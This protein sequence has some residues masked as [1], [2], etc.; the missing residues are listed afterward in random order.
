M[1]IH[2]T[3]NLSISANSQPTN[4]TLPKSAGLD[5]SEQTRMSKLTNQHDKFESN[6]V[7]FKGKGKKSLIKKIVE[8]TKEVVKKAANEGKNGDP[9]GGLFDKIL[10]VTNE[11]EV[12]IQAAIGAVLCIVA[13]PLTLLA[14]PGDKNK[15][16]CIYASAH[17]IS[18]GIWG[19]FVPFL[20]VT[21]LAKG[22]RYAK[23]HAG[24]FMTPE[25]I[26]ERWPH[27]DL[28][29]I[30]DEHGKIKAMSDWLDIKGRKF[31]P[32]LK[33][34][35]KIPL[36]KNIAEVSD[37]TMRTII[38]Q[39][40]ITSRKGAKSANELLDKSGKK[41]TID[42]V[43]LRE[44]FVAVEEEGTKGVKYYPLEYVNEEL[45][46]EI[47][48]DVNPKSIKGADGKRLHP[49]DWKGLQGEKYN[50]D[51]DSL[52]F[53][54]WNDTNT[55]TLLITGDTRVNGK[56]R[57]GAD[58]IKD[59]TYLKNN[60]D[61]ERIGTAITQEMVE[62]DYTN[63]IIDKFGGWFGDLLIAYPRATATI[64]VLPFIL[65]NVFHIEKTKKAPT[66]QMPVATPGKE[67]A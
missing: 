65:K 26:K 63:S 52:F 18:S 67:V 59:I 3:Q 31:L 17:S 55:G 1:K 37:D 19:L 29:S 40:D 15:K 27:V 6:S 48:P 4:I 35:I 45:L 57:N 7:S 39:I 32:D 16:D 56:L 43:P 11:Q 23:E 24:E 60:R 21:P 49:K 64:A 51:M 58:D 66:V 53:S 12:I 61:G 47:M 28:A 36:P 14:F 34:V 38:P 9:N 44:I 42:A 41:L 33:D 50:Y 46:L 20:F 54:N 2:T 10:R 62:A 13:R 5:Y 8:S 25:K 22:Y 30:K